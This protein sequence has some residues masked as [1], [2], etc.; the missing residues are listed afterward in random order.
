MCINKISP[1]KLL[2][3]SKIEIFFI[4]MNLNYKLWANRDK[5][6]C[7]IKSILCVNF[8]SFSSFLNNEKQV[9]LVL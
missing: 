6:R 9:K 3:F 5:R 7:N 2:I 4:V 1:D 8:N